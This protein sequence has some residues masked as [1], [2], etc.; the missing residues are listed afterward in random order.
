MARDFRVGIMFDREQ[1]PEQLTAFARL[2]E[3]G[4]ADDLWLV[5]D[6]SWGGSIAAAATVLANTQRLRVGIGLCP[7]PLRNP[8]LLAMELATLARLHPGRLAAGIGHGVPQ[9][10]RQVGAWPKSPLALLEETAHALQTL[11]RGQELTA[12]GKHVTIDGLRLVH[13]PEQVPPVLIGA[14]GPRTLRLAGRVGEGSILVEGLDP[15]HLAAT[16]AVVE[17]GRAERTEPGPHETV[18]LVYVHVS[19]DPDLS[20]VTGPVAAE[21]SAVL[22]VP[23]EEIFFA[24]GPPAKVAE[25]LQSLHEAGVDTFALHLV[26]EDQFE[27]ARRVL[28]ALC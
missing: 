23:V 20:H 24:A 9:W 11:L 13:P 7:A 2:V 6:L 15:K 19:D 4:G 8:A 14:M 21:L 27:Q 18:A 12:H 16:R 26:G 5:E 25:D 28:D 17:E 1:P 3:D 22:D 10:M